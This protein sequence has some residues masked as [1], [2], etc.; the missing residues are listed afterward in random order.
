MDGLKDALLL[1][2]DTTWVSVLVRT[3]LLVA[4]R[5]VGSC[6]EEATSTSGRDRMWSVVGLLDGTRSIAD[7]ISLRSAVL[8]SQGSGDAC[9]QRRGEER[10]YS[11]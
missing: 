6:E 11:V 1:N 8:Y 7:D 10:E 5:R 2:R 3:V 4:A 9:V